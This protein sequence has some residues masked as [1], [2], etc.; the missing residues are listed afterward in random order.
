MWRKDW[1]LCE[2]CGVR[3]VGLAGPFPRFCDRC[4][5]V[6]G[7]DLGDEVPEPER[8]DIRDYRQSLIDQ[9]WKP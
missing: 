3:G 2:A 7:R 6:V 1:P 9:R 8:F 4:Q 5:P